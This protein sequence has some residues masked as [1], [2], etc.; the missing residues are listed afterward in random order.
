MVLIF[1]F[2][3]YGKRGLEKIDAPYEIEYKTKRGFNWYFKCTS[4]ENGRS[5]FLE[6]RDVEIFA[7]IKINPREVKTL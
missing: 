7:K 6:Q 3:R 5:T 1:T 2:W 4:I